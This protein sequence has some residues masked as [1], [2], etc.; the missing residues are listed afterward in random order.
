MLTPSM[1]SDVSAIEVASTTLRWPLGA[2][3]MAR[4]CTADSSAPNSGT[5]S[6]GGIVDAL[7]EQILRCGEFRRRPAGTPAPSRDR[8]ATPSRSHPPSAARAAR[9]LCGRDSG[10]RPERRGLRWR[11]RAPRQAV[12]PPGRH[13][14]SPTS[15][16]CADPRASRSARRAPAPAR[17]R[18]RANARE[19]RRTARRQRPSVPDLPESAAKKFP[20]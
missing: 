18:H 3:A 14:A 13:R 10:S 5:T 19:I 15:Q 8:R 17:D 12:L 9:P 11:S 6:T 7:A 1:V 2:G 16:E 20:R 4:S